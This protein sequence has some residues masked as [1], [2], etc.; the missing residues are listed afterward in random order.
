[1]TDQL[2]TVEV[3]YMCEGEDEIEVY[4]FPT[5][6]LAEKCWIQ[7]VIRFSKWT[8]HDFRTE[9]E[10]STFGY[11]VRFNDE[12]KEMS[13]ELDEDMKTNEYNIYKGRLSVKTQ[14]SKWNYGSEL[15]I[16][17]N[18]RKIQQN[19]DSP[20]SEDETKALDYIFIPTE[21]C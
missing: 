14:D 21:P 4:M 6:E 15:M 5:S 18:K 17:L 11:Y 12:T 10:K 2:Y 1:M 19:L 8:Y 13:I 20:K 3:K 7:Q 9:K 16:L